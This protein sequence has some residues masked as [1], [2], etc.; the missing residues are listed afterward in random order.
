[1]VKQSTWPTLKRILTYLWPMKRF[2]VV[3]VLGL[4]TYGV[5]D[6]SFIYLLKP[7]IDY[8][9]IPEGRTL[10]VSPDSFIGSFA[11]TVDVLAIAPFILL[12]LFFVRGVAN[13]LSTYCLAYLSAKLIEQMRQ[14]VVEH[15]MKLPVHY[16]DSQ[17]SGT[18]ISKV[19][20]DIE[21]VANASGNVLT[22]V[23]RETVTLFAY[24]GW[25][26][27]LS[28]QLSLCLIVTLPVMGILIKYVA[29][30]FRK[31]S[32]QIQASMGDITTATDQVVRGHKNILMFGGQSLEAERFAEVNARN[33]SKRMK[34]ALATA[35][36]QPMIMMIGACSLAF[37]LYLSSMDSV[38]DTM[39][40]G[41]FASF[42]TAM[43]S[44]LN[45][46]KNL[47]RVNNQLQ[48]GIAAADSVFTTL[49]IDTEND[50]GSE[51]IQQLKGHI[52]FHN[53]D[54]SYG[55]DSPIVL[56]KVNL[57]VKPNKTL[58]LIGPSGSGKS[59]ITNLIT[60][61]YNVNDGMISLDGRD[62]RDYSLESLRSQIAIVSQ[63]V[64]L[65]NDTIANNIAYACADVSREQIVAAAE[66]AYA[67]NFISE[68]PQGIDTEIGENG[69]LL[70]GGQRQRIAIARAILRDAPILILDEATSALDTESERMIQQALEQLSKDRTCIVVAHRLSTIENADQIAVIDHGRVVEYGSHHAL[71]QKEGK[72]KQLHQLQFAMS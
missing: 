42:F 24:I 5:V 30:R 44:L 70:S 64:V 58:A 54:F 63:S 36:S 61:F 21:L 10:S 53:V 28:W 27:W 72:Y 29:Q 31:I 41:T 16:M 17:N 48:Q 55:I 62:I 20:Y 2:F 37:V 68:L 9:F 47:M 60:R 67:M 8:G 45:P 4:I 19:T 35:L 46:V 12:F 13:F 22:T 49:G 25:M 69:I 11:S 38:R 32:K 1:M 40:A 57:D 3:A 43:V 23:I 66:A 26:L 56:D 15:Y 34:L 39:T 50:S 33:R 51:R 52:Q 59:T 71:L 65:F 6:A 14:E 7:F 18:L